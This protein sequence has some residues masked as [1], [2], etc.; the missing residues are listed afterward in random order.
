MQCQD[1]DPVVLRK[2]DKPKPANTPKPKSDEEDGLI[3]K[4]KLFS[5]VDFGKRVQ[6]LRAA[7]G[8]TRKQ[9]AQKMMVRE[10]VLENIEQGNGKEKYNGEIV[11]KLK[12]IL[13]NL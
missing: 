1:W 13:K 2:S 9:L 10:G 11:K 3:K 8:L 4:P 12:E 5:D 6:S 7:E